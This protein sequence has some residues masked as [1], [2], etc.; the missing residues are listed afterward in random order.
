MSIDKCA[1]LLRSMIEDLLG[2]RATAIA[3]AMRQSLSREA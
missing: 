1:E 2:E 3:T